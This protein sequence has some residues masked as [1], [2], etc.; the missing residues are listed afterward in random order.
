LHKPSESRARGEIWRRK[1]GARRAGDLEQLHKV[2][3]LAVDV[4][5]ECDWRVHRLN[6][7]L[8][9]PQLPAGMGE[10]ARVRVCAERNHG[11]AP[12]PPTQPTA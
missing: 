4:P 12:V 11:V 8:L 5:A 7:A 2:V 6:V 1:R 3:E 10:C 9:D